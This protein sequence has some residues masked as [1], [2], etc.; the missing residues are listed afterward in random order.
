MIELGKKY[1]TRDGRSVR[2]L[3]VDGPDEYW[4]VVGFMGDRTMPDVWDKNG[5]FTRREGYE[6]D[7][8]P[9]LTKHEGWMP[10][11]QEEPWGNRVYMGRDAALR[12]ASSRSEGYVVRVTWED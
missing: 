1:Q 11:T 2:I 9:V 5:L 4:P 12:E 10:I 6:S 8:I 7:L 3:C